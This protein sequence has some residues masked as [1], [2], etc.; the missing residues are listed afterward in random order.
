MSKEGQPEL[1]G[2]V[3]NCIAL[4]VPRDEDASANL[5]GDYCEVIS[6]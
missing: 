3:E 5:R 1:V 6:T 2:A 4:L